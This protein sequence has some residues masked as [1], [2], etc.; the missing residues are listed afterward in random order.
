MKYVEMYSNMVI[1][2]LEKYNKELIGQLYSSDSEKE[3]IQ[4][5]I[6]NVD[7]ELYKMYERLIEIA[8]EEFEFNNNI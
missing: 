8:K 1:K 5:L 6:E 4:E 2:P 3:E 7:K